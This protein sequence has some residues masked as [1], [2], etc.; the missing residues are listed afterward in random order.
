MS[1]P[2]VDLAELTG[3]L[4][5]EAGEADWPEPAAIRAAGDRRRRHRRARYATAVLAVAVAA[6]VPVAWS[7]R[8]HRPARTPVAPAARPAGP[9]CRADE[10]SAPT[11]RVL[12]GD[13]GDTGY[14]IGVS[15]TG[16]RRCTLRD[17]PRVSGTLANGQAFALT[18]TRLT[19]FDPPHTERP[20]TLDPGDTASLFLVIPHGCGGTGSRYRLESLRVAGR[21]DGLGGT[22]MDGTGDCAA[23]MG[24]WGRE[25]S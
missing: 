22:E 19:V 23:V 18:G 16:T 11:I 24:P 20:P 8:E 25:Q 6:V 2:R 10:L 21:V 17:T 5:T 12:T 9:D 7:A 14:W 3:R 13:A 4:R 15:N 1:E